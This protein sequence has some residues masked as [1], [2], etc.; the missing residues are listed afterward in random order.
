MTA[1][2]LREFLRLVNFY[3]PSP[4]AV[5]I[6]QPLYKLLGATKRGAL[7]CNGLAKQ[8]WLSWLLGALA[9]ATLLTYPKPNAPTSIMCD[10]SDTAVG[11]VLQLFQ[12]TL[13]HTKLIRHI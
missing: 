1:C 5:C 3:H 12:T 10:V 13:A 6:L 9:R 8:L 2:K 7:S 11:A 4:N